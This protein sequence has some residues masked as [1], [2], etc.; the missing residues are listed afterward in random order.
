M[1]AQA[2]LVTGNIIKAVK[3]LQRLLRDDGLA[4]R[5]PCRT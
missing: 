3:K 1:G 4:A 5:V 2:E